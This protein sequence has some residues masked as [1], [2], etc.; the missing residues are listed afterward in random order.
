MTPLFNLILQ[1][2]SSSLSLESLDEGGPDRKIINA[3][4][5]WEIRWRLG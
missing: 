1:A 5:N 2:S 3:G 4:N